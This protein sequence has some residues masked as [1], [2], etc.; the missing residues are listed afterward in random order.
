[1]IFKHKLSKKEGF[2]VIWSLIFI[3]E[4]LFEKVCGDNNSPNTHFTTRRHVGK[5]N[6]TDADTENVIYAKYGPSYHAPN[7]NPLTVTS[8]LVD[9]AKI[10]NFYANVMQLMFTDDTNLFLSYKNIDAVFD[11]K[12]VKISQRGLNQTNC[13]WMLIKLNGCYFILASTTE[14][15]LERLY[16]CQKHAA[17]VYIYMCVCVCVWVRGCV[18]V[19]LF[20]ST[21][22]ASP[23][24][25]K[26]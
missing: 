9:R 25:I 10:R 23:D 14:S 13:L 20:P 1:M 26:Q 8:C 12:I 17:R 6:I 15:K 7:F 3:L 18:F 16:R 24:W 5:K 22:E 11:S 19:C 21:I 2:C 4:L